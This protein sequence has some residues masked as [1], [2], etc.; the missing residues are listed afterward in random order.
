MKR[1]V[2]PGPAV[3]I[4]MLAYPVYAQS[5][6]AGNV[7]AITEG[8]AI[9]NRVCTACHG[10]DGADGER[11]PALAST[12]RRYQR[13]TDAQLFDAIEHGIPDTQMPPSGLPEADGWKVTTYLRSLRAFAFE[14]PASGNVAHGEEVFWNKGGCGECHMLHGKGG[15]IGPD[16]SSLA[17]RRRLTSIRE[18]LT[19]AG[20]RIA[21]DG[22][23]QE[24]GLKTSPRYQPVR[25][26]TRD[27][28]IISGVIRN[29]DSFSLQILGS[30]E[31]VHLFLR[32]ELRQITYGS[33]SLMPGDYD[34]RLSADELQD[35]LAFLSR[36]G[37][38]AQRAGR[39][40]AGP[41]NN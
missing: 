12:A 7:Q 40:G 4:L 31:T 23:R 15:L 37:T 2:R 24:P 18:A 14:M 11:A 19:D 22:G 35:L 38:G 8:R 33:K 10:Y 30:D 39:G 9:Y 3:M 6:F 25:V 16:L 1:V 13:T 27:G 21:T 5:P 29:E 41:Q 28:R 34:R 26:M 17:S 36:Q 32:D 20:H